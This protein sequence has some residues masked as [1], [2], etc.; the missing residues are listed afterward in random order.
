MSEKVDPQVLD[1]VTAEEVKTIAGMPASLANLALNDAVALARS[2]NQ[3]Y[4]S[5]MQTVA[6]RCVDHVLD[7]S[8]ADASAHQKIASGN[9]LG[10]QLAQLGAVIAQIQQS[11]KGAQTTPPQ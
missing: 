8:I 9:D 3:A 6:A 5:L 7:T 2:T 4:S 11:M 1:A 10:Q